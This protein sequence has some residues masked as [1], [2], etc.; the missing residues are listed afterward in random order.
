MTYD[1]AIVGAGPVGLMLANL[2]GVYGVRTVV[3]ERKAATVD[4]PRAIAI[5]AESLRAV[6]AVGLY[7]AVAPDLLLG[8]SVDYVNGRGTPL[9][10][11]ELGQTP[12]GHAQQNAFHQP[13][14]EQALAGGLTRFPHVDVR[15]GHAVERFDATAD[16][17][18]VFGA[19]ADGTPFSCVA[20]YLVGCDGGRSPV[21]QALGIEMHGKSAPQRWLV[22]DTIDPFL[23]ASMECRFFC[24]PRRPAMT[25]R[26]QHQ[27][28]RWEWMLMPD[29]SEA[30]LLDDGMIARL[31]MPY[32]RPQHVQLERQCVYT[33]HSLVA[34]RYRAGRVMIAGDAAHMMPP[35]AGQGMNGGIRDA[36]NIAWKLALVTRGYAAPALLDSY[37]QERRGHVIAATALA[38]RLG[39]MIQPTSRW[40]A[41]LRDAF[42]FCL[43]RSRRGQVA[44][45]RRLMGTLIAPRLR[46]GVFVAASNT[47]GDVALSGQMI[48]QPPVRCADGSTVLLDAVLGAEHAVVGYGVDPRDALDAATQHRLATLGARLVCVMPRGV[49]PSGDAVEDGSGGLGTWFGACAERLVLIRPDRFCAAQFT[50]ATAAQTLAAYTTR[51]QVRVAE[52]RAAA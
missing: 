31:L 18:T 32:T 34:D 42:F 12:Y 26:K 36:V 8:F 29:E 6:R 52:A 9:L 17:V 37:E 43:N 5:D 28:R 33:F 35:F 46:R 16:A 27:R 13:L 4:E 10:H 50:A 19:A 45:L 44:L 21:R 48:V 20:Q 7:D 41:A 22:I 14:L 1:V 15:F 30:D 51:L 2:L 47:G 3:L 39:A 40:R 38:N 25:L 49:A 23:A 24:D 11:V